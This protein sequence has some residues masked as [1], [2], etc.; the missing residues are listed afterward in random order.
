MTAQF[1]LS[2]QYIGEQVIIKNTTYVYEE[3]IIIQEE[4][5]ERNEQLAMTVAS[6]VLVFGVLINLVV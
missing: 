4:R 2:K 5:R 3:E 1:R 6:G